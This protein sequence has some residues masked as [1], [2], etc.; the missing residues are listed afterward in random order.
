MVQRVLL[1]IEKM[2]AEMREAQ[3]AEGAR[4][5]AGESDEH[6]KAKSKWDAMVQVRR[7][8]SRGSS[9]RRPHCQG[10]QL[11]RS[12]HPPRPWHA[13]QVKARADIAAT[14]LDS[15]SS[16]RRSQPTLLGAAKRPSL[17]SPASASLLSSS[18][19]TAAAGPSAASASAPVPAATLAQNPTDRS[20]PSGDMGR[21]SARVEVQGR[22]VSARGPGVA[23]GEWSGEMTRGWLA[24]PGGRSPSQEEGGGEETGVRDENWPWGDGSKEGACS[25]T[26]PLAPGVYEV[27]VQAPQHYHAAVTELVPGSCTLCCAE[28]ST[29]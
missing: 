7:L 10:S 14:G 20:A 24:D 29:T 18:V 2:E 16:Q 3:E 22:E 6:A 8:W 23:Q 28:E 19:A 9:A 4:R 25:D 21:P 11:L 5:G 15:T 27:R 13:Q 1:G 12:S 17:A 26:A